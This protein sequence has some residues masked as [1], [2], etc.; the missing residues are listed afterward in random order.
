VNG[1]QGKKG[2]KTTMEGRNYIEINNKEKTMKT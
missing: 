1:E 2:N